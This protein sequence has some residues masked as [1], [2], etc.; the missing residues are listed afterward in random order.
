MQLAE[1]MEIISTR[2]FIR[3]YFLIS[4]CCFTLGNTNW[5]NRRITFKRTQN[6]KLEPVIPTIATTVNP[7]EINIA[8]RMNV[9]NVERNKTVIKIPQGSEKFSFE[10]LY[11]SC[12]FYFA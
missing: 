9:E 8:G 2:Q 12:V 11:V 4:F 1:K 3:M 7:N 5:L 10:M 6:N